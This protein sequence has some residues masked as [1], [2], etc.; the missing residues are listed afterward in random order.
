MLVE[1]DGQSGHIENFATIDLPLATPGSIVDVIVTGH[2]GTRLTG[3]I[4]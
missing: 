3:V 2:D 1:N 4:A